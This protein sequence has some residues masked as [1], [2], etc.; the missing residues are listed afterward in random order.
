MFVLVTS[1][2][3]T[4]VFFFVSHDDGITSIYDEIHKQKRPIEEIVDEKSETSSFY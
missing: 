1:L 2:E 4:I 3:S